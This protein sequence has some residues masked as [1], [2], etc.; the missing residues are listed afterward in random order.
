MRTVT[1]RHEAPRE[2]TVNGAVIA[3]AEIAREVQNHA[4][5]TAKEAWAD[6]TRALVIRE[7]LLQRAGSL[8]LQAEPLTEDGI[9]ETEE[10]AL[11]R[12][13]LAAEVHTPEAD[14][15]SCRRY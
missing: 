5:A 6:A 15:A 1:M 4:G 10:A 9:R 2:V 13:L 8:E 3:N 14:E 11:I 12:T 7:L